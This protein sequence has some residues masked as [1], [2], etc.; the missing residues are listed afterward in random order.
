MVSHE[1]HSFVVTLRMPFKC[2]LISL[3]FTMSSI[4]IGYILFYSQ[5]AVFLQ[6]DQTLC[7]VNGEED[8]L[9]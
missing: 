3:D 7:K 9:T 6:S 1:V 8:T 2:L 5:Y 4:L